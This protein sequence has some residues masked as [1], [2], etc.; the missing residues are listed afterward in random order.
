[1]TIG[2][3]TESVDK[4]MFLQKFDPAFDLILHLK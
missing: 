4:Y 2:G 1:M 3:L